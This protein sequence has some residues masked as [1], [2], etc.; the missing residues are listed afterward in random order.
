MTKKMIDADALLDILKDDCLS[1]RVNGKKVIYLDDVA[2][3]ITNMIYKL[4][5]QLIPQESI[6]DADGWCY[7]FDK[8][9]DYFSENGYLIKTETDYTT[10][11]CGH[12]Y[13]L[14]LKDVIAWR[15]LPTL[16]KTV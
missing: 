3:H 10:I 8:F 7:D 14:C 9:K 11:K 4:Y 5:P 12:Q 1:K 16:P 13:R 2:F 15:P 6:F